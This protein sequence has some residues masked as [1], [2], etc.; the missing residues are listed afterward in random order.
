MKCSVDST[1][2]P[3]MHFHHIHKKLNQ[4][5]RNT[6]SF[7]NYKIDFTEGEFLIKPKTVNVEIEKASKIYGEEDPDYTISKCVGSSPIDGETLEFCYK[8]LML[9]ISRAEAG[10]TVGNYLIN[11][12]YG[13]KNYIV[14]FNDDSYLTIEK[15]FIQIIV[16]GDS[17]TPGKYT[18]YYEDDIPLIEVYDSSTGEKVG[19]VKNKTMAILFLFM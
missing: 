14:L 6:L 5:Q 1:L 9:S 7:S 16:K 3:D 18:I 2:A 15:R 4:T 11:G 17:S 19:L 8:E 12:T 10:E 13:N